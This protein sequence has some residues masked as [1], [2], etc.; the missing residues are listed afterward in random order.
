M[1]IQRFHFTRASSQHVLYV[2]KPVD[3]DPPDD[4]FWFTPP[5]PTRSRIMTTIQ[6]YII[7]V[8]D[9]KI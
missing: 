6:Y 9:D 4:R 8:C 3:I 2:L 7:N 5:P 1:E